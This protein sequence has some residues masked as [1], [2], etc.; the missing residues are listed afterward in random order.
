MSF[1]MKNARARRVLQAASA[2]LFAVFGSAAHANWSGLNMPEGVTILSRK[3]RST[4]C[5]C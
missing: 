3:I 1:H 4:T 5:T 2:T